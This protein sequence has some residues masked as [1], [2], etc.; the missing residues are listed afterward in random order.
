M[1]HFILFTLENRIC[2]NIRGKA[3]KG[4]FAESIKRYTYYVCQDAGI[5][6]AQPLNET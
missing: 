1:M 3:A 2:W 6:L 5:D 4:V